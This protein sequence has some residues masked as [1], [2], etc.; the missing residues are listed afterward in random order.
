MT[1]SGSARALAAAAAPPP[2]TVGM[3][4]PAHAAQSRAADPLRGAPTVGTCSTMTLHQAGAR[5]DRSTVVPCGKSHTAQVAGVVQLP[6]RLH[7]KTATVEQLFRVVADKCAP[8]VNALL[9]R[10]DRARDS[11]AYHSVWFTPTK[12]QRSKGARWLSC[13]V[14]IYKAKSLA[15]LLKTKSPFLPDGTLPD[16]VAGCL[17]KRPYYTPCSAR[18]LWRATGTFVVSGSYPGA[19]KLNAKAKQKCASRVLAGRS[20]RWTYRDKITWNT[21]HDHVVVCYSK[22]RR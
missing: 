17:T 20:Y 15:P 18:H 12:A 5:A 1:I 9:G 10:D 14:V 13:S 16:R 7:W 11:S 21:G 8:K 19:T 6:D 2:T 3:L 4:S 22:T